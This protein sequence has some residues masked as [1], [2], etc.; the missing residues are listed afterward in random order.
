MV[1]HGHRL[2]PGPRIR[3]SVVGLQQ[4]GPGAQSDGEAAIGV[5]ATASR[6]RVRRLQDEATDARIGASGSVRCADRERRRRDDRADRQTE[7]AHTV[8]LPLPARSC[9]TNACA[10]GITKRRRGTILTV[11]FGDAR[12]TCRGRD[13]LSR[14]RLPGARALRR[15]WPV[16]DEP[17]QASARVRRPGPWWRRRAARSS[18]SAA[19][20]DSRHPASGCP[21]RTRAPAGPR[22]PRGPATAAPAPSRAGTG[23]SARAHSRVARAGAA[24]GRHS[25]IAHQSGLKGIAHAA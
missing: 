10:G 5:R 24:D 1:V 11:R 8:M 21:A 25:S 23:A 20:S 14:T 7:D 3:R 22:S 13:G 9:N 15:V 19:R 4:V 12:Q 16:A 2:C 18:S 6:E 17:T